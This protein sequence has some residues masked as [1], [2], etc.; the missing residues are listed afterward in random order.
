MDGR[1]P[2]PHRTRRPP[3]TAAHWTA[4][5][6]A[7]RLLCSSPPSPSSPPCPTP[8]GCQAAPGCRPR[9]YSVAGSGCARPEDINGLTFK[10]INKVE[11]GGFLWFSPFVLIIEIFCDKRFWRISKQIIWKSAK[12]ACLKQTKASWILLRWGSGGILTLHLG[13]WGE[14]ELGGSTADPD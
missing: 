1:T 3:W 10:Y 8:P 9:A 11:C 14:G 4:S 12:V 5:A 13:S 6:G 2:L 7:A